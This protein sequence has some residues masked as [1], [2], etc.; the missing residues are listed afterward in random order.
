MTHVPYKPSFLTR[1]VIFV[2]TSF[3]SFVAGSI[4]LSALI[5]LGFIPATGAVSAF[6]FAL[7][8]NGIFRPIIRRQFLK[9][10]SARFVRA[11]QHA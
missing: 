7:V 9:L 1:V 6:P 3:V 10:C 11:Q 4:I 8:L 2:L 5:S